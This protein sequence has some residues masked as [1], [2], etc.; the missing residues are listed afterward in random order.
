MAIRKIASDVD[1]IKIRSSAKFGPPTLTH[2]EELLAAGIHPTHLDSHRHIHTAFPIGRLVVRLAKRYRIPYVRSARN[3][4]DRGGIESAY[5]WMFNRYVASHVRTADHF[6]D[7]VDF[8]ERRSDHAVPG[9]IECMT[10][11]DDSPRG[12]DNRRLL[13]N[14]EFLRFRQNYELIGHAEMSH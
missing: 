9:V 12:L 8:Y 2:G 5:K 1:L 6:G 10:H 7:I 4:A 3:L 13:E 11:L 14:Q